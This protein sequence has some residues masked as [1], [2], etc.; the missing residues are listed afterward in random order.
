MSEESD[1]E[2]RVASGED[3]DNL[4][5]VDSEADSEDDSEVDSEESGSED[6]NGFID[7]EASESD[8]RTDDEDDLSSDGA[9]QFYFPQ[10]MQ[11][12]PEL[13]ARVWDFFD[14]DLRA[15]ARVFKLIFPDYHSEVWESAFLDEQTAPARAMLATHH[16]SREL[17][18]K[19]YPDALH[20]RSGC[21]DVRFNNAKDVVLIHGW[22]HPANNG[23]SLTNILS[24]LGDPSYLAFESDS[25][26]LREEDELLLCSGDESKPRILFHCNDQYMF[27]GRELQ[28][29]ISDI[30][31]TYHAEGT[32]EIEGLPHVVETIYCWPD[33]GNPEEL[34]L[35]KV[36][37]LVA[38]P[39]IQWWPMVEFDKIERY[40][41]LQVAVATEGEWSDKWSTTTAEHS[42]PQPW[43]EDEYESDGIDD[44]TID[45]EDDSSEDG[46][47]LV[48]QSDDVEE[49]I[50]STF[51]GFSPLQVATS[52]HSGDEIGVGNFSSL[53]PESPGP[54]TYADAHS[55]ESEH[56]SEHAISDE[57]PIQKSS[58]RKR[59][60]ISSDDEHDDEDELDGEVK[61]PSRPNKR[62]RIVLS[63]TEDEDG[64]DGDESAEHGQEAAG[65]SEDDEDPEEQESDGSEESEPV[66]AKPLSLFEKLKQFRDE[67]PVSPDSGAGSDA[68][69]NAE[70]SLDNEDFDDGSE[71][72]FLDDEVDEDEMLDNG[73]GES[74]EEG[75]DE[76]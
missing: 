42:S 17:A 24:I 3:D 22:T 5:E 47:D 43:T 51:N 31:H 55:H 19:S 49:D 66:K 27:S 28:W 65:G 67:N 41:K 64:E 16:E 38:R 26:L 23:V 54:G 20:I 57:E 13:R 1:L 2:D 60:I 30:A 70:A 53:E 75:D 50:A 61:L 73:E 10:F 14:P 25:I 46:D 63:D 62:P 39:G 35:E 36:K 40:R 58:R 56:D 33:F 8:G 18:L 71:T 29:C 15:K 6:A 69:S 45:E 72:K 68:G 12:P 7:M 52:E 11:L 37:L 21:Y 59:R 44:A 34:I 76:W 32:E 48:V 74:F 9:E 4:D